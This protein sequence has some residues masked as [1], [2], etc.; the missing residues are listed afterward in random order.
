MPRI[1]IRYAAAASHDCEVILPWIFH[2]SAMADYE[3][4]DIDSQL[5]CDEIAL[6]E[7]YVPFPFIIHSKRVRVE[8]QDPFNTYFLLSCYIDHFTK[9]TY[10]SYP[11]HS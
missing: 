3:G 6:L 10:C 2:P 7:L 5:L 9:S 11:L 8:I 1:D 4:S